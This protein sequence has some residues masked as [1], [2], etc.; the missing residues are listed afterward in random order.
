MLL[1][2]CAGLACAV[3]EGEEKLLA[4][5]GGRE[6]TS[7]TNGV[8]VICEDCIRHWYDAQRELLAES[9]QLSLRPKCPVCKIGLRS[10]STRGDRSRFMG[11]QRL[12]KAESGSALREQTAFQFGSTPPAAV[13]RCVAKAIRGVISAAVVQ[14]SS[15][16]ILDC[17]TAASRV[18]EHTPTASS[19]STQP[20]PPSRKR[21]RSQPTARSLQE[22]KA[23]ESEESAADEGLAEAAAKE[24]A[25]EEEEEE[26]AEE[27]EEE[28]IVAEERSL[29]TSVQSSHE[30]E[31][32]STA[33]CEE[34]MPQDE[35]MRIAASEGLVLVG[36]CERSNRA[37]YKGVLTRR[38]GDKQVYL[39][40]VQDR[41]KK[42][43]KQFLS[44]PEAPKRLA[45][46]DSA[47]EAALFRARA[48]GRAS[49][50]REQA[51]AEARHVQW[52]QHDH[53]LTAELSSEEALRQAA[54]EG[55][56]LLVRGRTGAVPRSGYAHV[57]YRPRDARPYIAETPGSSLARDGRRQL[58]RFLSAE[59][60]ALVVARHI[61]ATSAAVVQR[62]SSSILDCVTA[63]SRVLEHTPTA[64]SSSTQPPPPSR[65]RR[66]SQPTA[67]SLQEEKAD[68]SEE[69]AADEGLAEAA[70]KEEAV[71]EEEEEAAEEEEEEAI[72]AEER[73]LVTSV[74]SSHEAEVASTARCEEGMP[75]DE[76]MRIAASE[77][78]VL[79]GS[80]E[81]S[82]RAG[83]KGV[84]T[85]RLGDKQVYLAYVQDRNKKKRKQFLSRPEAPKRLAHFDSA[86]EAA[87]F[88][89]RAIGR[90]SALREQAQA[91]ARH[92]QWAQHDHELTAE[93][94]SEEA[95]RQ[96][97][98]EGL[99]LLVRG[100]TGAVPRSG[101]AHVIYRPRD[102]RPYIAETPGSSLARDGRRQLGRFLSAEHAALVVARHIAAIG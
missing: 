7:A 30:A 33:R 43:R 37:G 100:R 85:R 87:L 36:S 79:V 38:L 35:A 39:A 48:I 45:H 47:P 77:G 41:N 50:L 6:L 94:S 15:S 9:H 98:C 3:C 56:T 64:S 42:K 22:E 91:E 58:G 54:C 32:A 68:E 88:R 90:A 40:Y 51:Q 95:L 69:S 81:R 46:F 27:E 52:A 78:L 11:L 18:L 70:A 60:A 31:V 8:H 2:E 96:A 89:A 16:S 99:T 80:C 53:E 1:E 82:N 13:R 62:S 17:V 4:C 34:G 93:L 24:E 23:D 66:R 28:A 61:A 26:A 84:L 55:L 97:A 21:R 14:R 65:K 71:E 12:D 86:P 75:Q 59:H 10:T 73:S 76:A 20:P 63:A 5:R 74:Q 83:Y 57:I 29:V 92:V 101:Y 72:V 67:R 25:V 44:R 19:S 49:A 102:A